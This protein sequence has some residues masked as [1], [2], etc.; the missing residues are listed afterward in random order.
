MKEDRFLHLERVLAP[1]GARLRK[2]VP[3]DWRWE[4]Q[5]PGQTSEAYGVMQPARRSQRWHTLYLTLI[6]EFTPEQ[7]RIVDVT[8]NYL[9]LFFDSPLRRHRRIPLEAIPPAA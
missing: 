7:E 4:H 1:L 6:G 9:E 8:A 5:E 2:P 3:G